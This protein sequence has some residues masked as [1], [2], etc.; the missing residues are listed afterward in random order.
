MYVH[1]MVRKW[2]NE[3]PNTWDVMERS[4]RAEEKGG[5]EEGSCEVEKK[6]S[7]SPG[8]AW[9]CNNKKRTAIL[10][11]LTIKAQAGKPMM[12]ATPIKSEDQ[13]TH[14]SVTFHLSRKLSR[15]RHVASAENKARRRHF[16]KVGL[17]RLWEE[18]SQ[19]ENA[20]N[21][22]REL[23]HHTLNMNQALD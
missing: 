14:L 19:W 7:A 21:R 17:H 10:F 15:K 13:Q 23:Q 18:G 8:L 16:E 3:F 4:V 12:V 1:F 5:G 9:V 6:L 22:V 11:L 20:Q 2:V